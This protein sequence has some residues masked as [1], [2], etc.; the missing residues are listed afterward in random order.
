M[1]IQKYD[2]IIN[3]WSTYVAIYPTKEMLI[4]YGIAVDKHM[5]VH[6]TPVYVCMYV[7]MLLCANTMQTHA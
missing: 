5:Y 4:C 7:P 1:C 3:T 6:T 2:I